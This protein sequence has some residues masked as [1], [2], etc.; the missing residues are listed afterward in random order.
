[1]LIKHQIATVVIGLA[2]LS[3]CATSEKWMEDDVYS[4]KQ[5]ILPTDTDV[6]DETDYSSYVYNRTQNDSK[7]VTYANNAQ[8]DNFSPYNSRFGY[9]VLLISNPYNAN[10]FGFGSQYHYSTLWHYN[11]AVSWGYYGYNGFYPTYGYGYGYYGY[12]SYYNPY[13]NSYYNSYYGNASWGNGSSNASAST[14]GLS[15]PRGSISGMGGSTSRASGT[16]KSATVSSYQPNSGKVINTNVSRPVSARPNTAAVPRPSSSTASRS[17]NSG[18]T[19]SSGVIS[20]SD[21]GATI[22]RTSGVSGSSTV[23]TSSPSSG[24]SS[25]RGGGGSGSSSGVKTVGRH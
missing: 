15:G 3:S 7:K 25:P 17:G 8:L 12:G 19:G 10:Y 4:V 9:S 5:A 14:H 16:L 1:M 22:T 21:R 24:N 13:Y 2:L 11:P 23:R 6:T 20:R 18:S